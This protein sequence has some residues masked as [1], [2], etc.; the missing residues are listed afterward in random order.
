MRPHPV[1]V[2]TFDIIDKTLSTYDMYN[3]T[4]VHTILLIKFSID[5]SLTRK[6]KFTCDAFPPCNDVTECQESKKLFDC[7]MPTINKYRTIDNTCNNLKNPL[8]GAS[9]T[10]FRRV[11]DAT[12]KDDDVSQA[13]GITQDL[14]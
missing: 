6:D 2:Y 11:L 12:Y 5:N 3:Y 4:I 1:T 13:T 9:D 8:L 7:K 10:P 14:K